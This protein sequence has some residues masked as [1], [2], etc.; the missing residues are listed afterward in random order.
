M[1][2]VVLLFRFA[3]SEGTYGTCPSL[4]SDHTC[5]GHGACYGQRCQCFD[6]YVGP[7]CSKRSCPVGRAWQDRAHEDDTAHRHT[8]CS[9]RG[10]C[11]YLTGRC[12]CNV[13]FGG[14]ACEKLLCPG[15]TE[16]TFGQYVAGTSE[17]SADPT[18]VGSALVRAWRSRRSTCSGRGLCLTTREYARRVF[19]VDYAS[20]LWDVDRIYGCH[21]DEGYE[22][23][24][25]SLRSCPRGDDPHTNDQVD[26]VQHL[27]CRVG[28]RHHELPVDAPPASFYVGFEDKW[29]REIFWN[30][31]IET[32]EIK[33][34]E[35]RTIGR[36]SVTAGNTAC[37]TVCCNEYDNND[38]TDV[39]VSRVVFQRLTGD[40]PPLRVRMSTNQHRASPSIDVAVAC[41]T[42]RAAQCT[43]TTFAETFRHDTTVVR[44]F[45]SV[46]GTREN[47]P[48]SGRGLC[49]TDSGYC[50]CLT[51]EYGAQYTTSDGRGG[52]GGR[53]DCGYEMLPVTSCDYSAL[54]LPCSG[55]GRC[56]YAG[57]DDETFRCECH[58]GWTAFDCSERTCPFGKAWFGK[59]RFDSLLNRFVAHDMAE[60]SNRG[61]CDRS[62]GQ[63]ECQADFTGA[64]CNMLSCP[65]GGI[66]VDV[67]S[68]HGTCVSMYDWARLDGRHVTYGT[69]PHDP[70]TWDFDQIFGCV[71]DEAYSGA[72]CAR[73]ECPVGDNPITPGVPDVQEL[74]CVMSR[75]HCFRHDRR[76]VHVVE[77]DGI[78]MLGTSA[79]LDDALSLCDSDEECGAVFEN[80]PSSGHLYYVSIQYAEHTRDEQDNGELVNIYLK[81]PCH[82]RFLYNSVAS[83]AIVS[84]NA[85]AHDL[86]RAL[87][88]IP[89]LRDATVV[90]LPHDDGGEN[91][92]CALSGQ[93]SFEVTLHGTMGSPS[94]IRSVRFETMLGLSNRFIHV[95][96]EDD[97]PDASVEYDSFRVTTIRTQ[98]GTYE[99]S[100][101]SDQGVCNTETGTCAC[102]EGYT[103]SNGRGGPGTNLDCGYL[104]PIPAR[105]H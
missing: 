62:T 22:G 67:C 98:N 45:A 23:Y 20:D 35:I 8:E 60:C 41:V 7:S 24:D 25:C 43:H 66:L 40:L 9:A 27:R 59:P 91:V 71:C 64:A 51:T 4:L 86:Q 101:C 50:E 88:T 49:L 5:S 99:K 47:L 84:P 13:G 63:C 103:A 48:C 72:N 44:V 3:L 39:Q 11:D 17:S 69:D 18:G 70:V 96:A 95:D 78:H 34:N 21:C 32:F 6:G 36:V 56:A 104:N 68:G 85:S 37:D 105:T 92:F 31:P 74:S 16:S 81:R 29:S 15:S 73:R 94:L 100:P 19:G 80:H 55:H 12:L 77:N 52:P 79:T 46:M 58:E 2:S 102:F 75:R 38:E 57:A 30:D 61:I 1:L 33:L 90:R 54:G 87:R 82:V 26:E 97:H 53:G 83:T 93:S 42:R 10:V 14:M 65:T 76:A 89:D 28:L